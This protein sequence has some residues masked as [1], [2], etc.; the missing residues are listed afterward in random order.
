M[1]E[2]EYEVWDAGDLGCGH[3]LIALRNRLRAMPGG[4]L[5]LIALDPGAPEDLPAWCRLTGNELLQ[6]D[7]AAHAF[8][9]RSRREG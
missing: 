3:L 4:V 6:H 9:I 1:T 2:T 8:W 5:K 7:A